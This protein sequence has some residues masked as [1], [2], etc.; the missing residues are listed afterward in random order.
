M[1]QTSS[2]EVYVLPDEKVEC[3]LVVVTAVLQKDVSDLQYL[4]VKKSYCRQ[5]LTFGCCLVPTGR[6]ILF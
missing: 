1:P 2:S 6:L 4:Y 5:T 3:L